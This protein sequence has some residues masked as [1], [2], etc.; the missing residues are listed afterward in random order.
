MATGKSKPLE[1]KQGFILDSQVTTEGVNGE[2]MILKPPLLQCSE[3]WRREG[4]FFSESEGCWEAVVFCTDWKA[5]E[6]ILGDI[7]KS[8]SL[9]K[10]HQTYCII[11]HNLICIRHDDKEEQVN[12]RRNSLLPQ[13]RVWGV[14]ESNHSEVNVPKQW[15]SF[16]CSRSTQCQQKTSNWG[17]GLLG[18]HPILM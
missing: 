4:L 9:W 6:V 3:H 2:K 11:F 15:F 1:G 13:F 5:L 17:C 7:N 8:D 10:A 16:Y 12:F 14:P 18:P